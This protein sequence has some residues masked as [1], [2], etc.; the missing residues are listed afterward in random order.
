[1]MN[2][3]II[4]LLSLAACASCDKTVSSTNAATSINLGRH[5]VLSSADPRASNSADPKEKTEAEIIE[6]VFMDCR[7]LVSISYNFIVDT[8]RVYDFC[9]Y[10]S[11][12]DTDFAI[13]HKNCKIPR[14]AS[15]NYNIDLKRFGEHFK[16]HCRKLKISISECAKQRKDAAIKKT[17]KRVAEWERTRLGSKY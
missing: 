5:Q 1:M 6:D 2:I 15:T 7:K 8:I 10:M 11:D 9:D 16:H 13:A 3:K 17:K 14:Q 4:L 12:N